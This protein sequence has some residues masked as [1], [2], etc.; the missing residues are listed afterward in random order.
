M[1]M[2]ENIKEQQINYYMTEPYPKKESFPN[3]TISTI[4]FILKKIYTLY[5]INLF[6]F[7][8]LKTI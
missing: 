3:E 4:D 1:I 6:N 5:S 7:L 2:P 8:R